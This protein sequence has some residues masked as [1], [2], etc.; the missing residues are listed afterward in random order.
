MHSHARP[1]RRRQVLGGAVALLAG[2]ATSLLHL[3]LVAATPPPVS[4]TITNYPTGAG[5]YGMARG[6]LNGNGFQDIVIVNFTDGTITILLNH[7]NGVLTPATNSPLKIP[8]GDGGFRIGTG[9]FDNT[10]K[11]AIVIVGFQH[12]TIFP[13]NTI[14][15]SSTIALGTGVV[16]NI[17]SV[18]AFAIGDVNG[19]GIQDIA[20]AL[21]APSPP[22]PTNTGTI[23]MLFGKGN[24]T[25]S[26]GPSFPVPVVAH[27]L[28]LHDL[29]GDGLPELIA[30]NT[31]STTRQDQLFVWNPTTSGGWAPAAGSPYT[32]SPYSGPAAIGILGTGQQPVIAV[33]C[34]N[35]GPGGNVLDILQV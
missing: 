27:S 10:G 31:A 12:L 17:G 23:T 9:Y 6:D 3:P 33:S 16:A 29:N 22:A 4:F 28:A 15:G 1:V 2:G 24:G 20:C 11:P 30:S 14:A 7:G 19:D 5:P 26:V 35:T 25:F 21:V 18:S 34:I 32:T 13:N 8:G